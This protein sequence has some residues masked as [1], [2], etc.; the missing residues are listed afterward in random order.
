M[1]TLG[2][3]S[4]HPVDYARWLVFGDPIRGE[5]QRREASLHDD[6]ETPDN[7]MSRGSSNAAT[8]FR[9]EDLV[10]LQR[11]RH[12][13]RCVLY[14]ENGFMELSP[15]GWRVTWKD[16]KP[17]P[18]DKGGGRQE[19]HFQNFIDCVKSRAKP[20]AEILEGHLSSRLCHLGN[21]ATRLGRRLRF[22]AKTE[23]FP[24]DD[25]AN[26]LLG[27]EHRAGFALPQV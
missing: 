18:T 6:Q 22:D 15:Q 11:A 25:E 3:D 4:V 8:W 21:I 27:R 2:N 12:G 20:N 24:G 10:S 13:K 23:M 7:S 17:G 5:R 16:Q 14:G 19:R 9:D 26:R 1:A